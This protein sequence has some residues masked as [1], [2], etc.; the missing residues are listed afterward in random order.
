MCCILFGTFAFKDS[1]FKNKLV[2]AVYPV[3]HKHLLKFLRDV[4]GS[5]GDIKITEDQNELAKICTHGGSVVCGLLSHVRTL[6]RWA[7][8]RM[9]NN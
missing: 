4:C 2:I 5:V 8:G 9:E 3:S 6:P 1:D 7:G